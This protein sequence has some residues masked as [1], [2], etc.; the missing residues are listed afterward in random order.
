MFNRVFITAAFGDRCKQVERLIKNIR[1]FSKLP[2]YII[3]TK[4][5]KVANCD[6]FQ[7][8]SLQVYL[9]FVKR[10]WPKDSYRADIRNSNY[11]KIK[12]AKEFDSA[13][14]LDDDMFILNHQY[15]DGFR[16][17][18]QFGAALPLNPRI[19]VGFNA[20][21]A[22]VKQKDMDEILKTPI[23]APACNFS[24]FFICTR[25]TKTNIFL[26]EL[27]RQLKDNVCRGTLAIWKASWETKFTPIYLPEQWCVCGENAEYWK[28]YTIQLKGRQ[29]KVDPIMLHLGHDNVKKIFGID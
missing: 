3:T 6:V 12:F 19:F 23:F 4:D 14:L 17:A 16:L 13:C 28:N 29:V 27:L 8:R 9:K 25:F 11:Y 21:G 18:E 24:P 26:N 15:F 7:L 20:M 10:I 2:I 5:S 1:K 22:D